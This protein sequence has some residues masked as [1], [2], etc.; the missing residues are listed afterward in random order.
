M[1][2][3]R[4]LSLILL[5]LLVVAA[6][7]KADERSA[8]LLR[9]LELK[10]GQ[11]AGYEVQFMLR[12]EGREIAGRYRVRGESYHMQVGDA[13]VFSDGTSRWEVDP[14][15]QEVVVDVVDPRSHNI[16]QN[17]TRA[18]TFL[19]QDFTHEVRSEAA[20][21]ATLTLRPKSRSSFSE[22]TLVLDVATATPRLM[23]YRADGQKLH[24]SITSF[25]ESSAPISAFDATRYAD[26][27]LIDF[28]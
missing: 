20:G 27:E 23:I 21:L 10:V 16:L 4:T 17:P 14:A 8:E 28:R 7:L 1:K 3:L 19:D 11:M 24:I 12:I 6:P 5:A 18:F 15:K 22:V 13:E 2:N 25:A 9:A 26:F